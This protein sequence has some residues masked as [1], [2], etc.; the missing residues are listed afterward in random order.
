MHAPF[1]RLD[2]L[3]SLGSGQVL[4]RFGASVARR[5]GLMRIRLPACPSDT[6]CYTA[7]R[8]SGRKPASH[9]NQFSLQ[10]KPSS[11]AR[12]KIRRAGQA[13]GGCSRPVVAARPWAITGCPWRVYLIHA[14]IN[15]A[16]SRDRKGPKW[17]A[18]AV[19]AWQ[20]SNC[21]AEPLPSPE[22]IAIEAILPATKS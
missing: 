9:S 11:P 1:S 7:I 16:A 22:T 14:V 17:Q 3:Y 5:G 10:P 21:A 20:W 13:P 8:P 12:C 19:A 6:I 15:R 4:G 2:P 18:V